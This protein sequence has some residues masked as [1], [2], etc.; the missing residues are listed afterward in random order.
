MAAG[1][2]GF[3]VVGTRTDHGNDRTGAAVWTSPDA[4]DDFTL[5]DTD[6]ALQSATGE[7]VRGLGI[8]GGPRGYVAVGD[9]AVDGRVDDEAMIWTSPDGQHWARVPASDAS[10]GGPGDQL[11]ALAT[12]WGGGWAVAGLETVG[13]HTG[14]VVWSTRDGGRWLR[15]RVDAMGT[16]PDPLSAVT[17]LAEVDGRLLV[18]ARLGGRFALASSADGVTWKA[19]ALP[20]GAVPDPHAVA[21]VAPVG[22]GLSLAATTDDGTRL[23]WAPAS[24]VG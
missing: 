23:W 3:V 16:D 10:L 13:G 5:V 18:A 6:P 17:G 9:Q 7:T 24:V 14:V 1:P 21:V 2:A 20:A 4:R 22:G 8:A 19:I 12:A 11:A 15:T